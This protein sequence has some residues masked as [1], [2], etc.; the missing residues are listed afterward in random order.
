MT[1]I[2]ISD[3]VKSIKEESILLVDACF[4]DT[5]GS[6]N[7]FTDPAEPFDYAKALH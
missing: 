1:F 5:P 3:L 7:H 6:E 2:T 4:T